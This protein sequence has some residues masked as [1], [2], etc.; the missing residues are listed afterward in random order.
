MLGGLFGQLGVPASIGPMTTTTGAA[1]GAR[2]GFLAGAGLG[3]TRSGTGVLVQSGYLVGKAA[4]T[5]IGIAA[6]G[7]SGYAL[8]TVGYCA[9]QCSTD[10]CFEYP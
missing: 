3:L 9:Y 5:A 1:L 10:Q 4:T 6:A 7:A 8:G 2:A